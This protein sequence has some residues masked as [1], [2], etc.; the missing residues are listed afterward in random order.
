MKGKL[1]HALTKSNGFLICIVC[2]RKLPI[3][4]SHKQHYKL[5]APPKDTLRAPIA[6]CGCAC[7][8]GDGG[9]PGELISFG[10]GT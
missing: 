5:K 3:V 7:G 6:T 4:L 2:Q 8:N 1:V 9:I 10:V